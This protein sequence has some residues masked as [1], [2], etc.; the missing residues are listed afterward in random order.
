MAYPPQSCLSFTEL[1]LVRPGLTALAISGVR[2]LMSRKFPRRQAGAL[3][4]VVAFASL[5]G[6]DLML[7]TS[8]GAPAT[9]LAVPLAAQA[10]PVA[11]SQ[12]SASPPQAG[13]AAA[14]PVPAATAPPPTVVE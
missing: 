11:S 12:V 1:K 2:N 5:G 6:I 4:V 13:P 14:P 7:V 3:A 9:H 10:T 8:G